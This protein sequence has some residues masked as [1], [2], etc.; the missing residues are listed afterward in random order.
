MEECVVEDLIVSLTDTEP[1]SV[2][3]SE[4]VVNS[5]KKRGRP[6][7]KKRCVKS[8]V[9]DQVSNNLPLSVCSTEIIQQESVGVLEKGVNEVVAVV[10]EIF[11]KPVSGKVGRP[12]KDKKRQP[13]VCKS[14]RVKTQDVINN[15]TVE[16]VDSLSDASSLDSVSTLVFD[17]VVTTSQTPHQKAVAKY[18]HHQKIRGKP[19]YLSLS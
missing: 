14:K 18:T 4:V 5:S 12:K 10:G 6:I 8:Q 9:V 19:K 17:E 13:K 1:S 11:V 2:A 15:N 16:V 7:K 3:Q